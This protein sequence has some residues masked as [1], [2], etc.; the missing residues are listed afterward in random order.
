ME[1][2]DMLAHL[3]SK[4]EKCSDMVQFRVPRRVKTQVLEVLEKRNIALSTVL[5]SYLLEII[6]NQNGRTH[7]EPSS[8]RG[9]RLRNYE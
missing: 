5:R 4:N 6:E 7:E 2:K 3:S 1:N 8:A 9:N